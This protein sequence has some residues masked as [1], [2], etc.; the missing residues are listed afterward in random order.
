MA[1]KVKAE[2]NGNVESNGRLT[3]AMAAV[4]KANTLQIKPLR[5][6]TAIFEIESSGVPYMQLRFSQKGKAAYMLKQSEGSQ[7]KSKKTR[8][9]KD[10]DALYKEAFYVPRKGG[11][12]IPAPA[13][14]NALISACRTVGFKMTLAK[15]SIFVEPDDY[16]KHDGTPLVLI[17]GEPVRTDMTVRNATG[18]IDIRTRPQ[19]PKWR[20]NVRIRFDE[21]QF[22]FADVA[23]L[24]ARVGAQVGLGEGRPDSKSSAGLG[25]GLFNVTSAQNATPKAEKK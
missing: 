25:Y 14:R 23:N 6:T 13:F 10:F 5:E 21:D 2:T 7:G 18:V 4:E 24:L 22:S 20:A 16:D 3:E 15:L 12:G 19:W 11:Y 9:G 1:T 17:Y 8:E